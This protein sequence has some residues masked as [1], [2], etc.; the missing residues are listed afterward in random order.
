MGKVTIKYLLICFMLAM[1]RM[2]YA[3]D[4]LT[5][6]PARIYTVCDIYPNALAEKPPLYRVDGKIVIK[7]NW[8]R[9]M[10][11]FGAYLN[12]SHCK[13]G[14]IGVKFPT[15]DKWKVQ[16]KFTSLWFST[17][18]GSIK[19]EDFYCYCYGHMNYSLK[20]PFM[21]IEDAYVPVLDVHSLGGGH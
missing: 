13:D 8:G 5:S 3:D 21:E 12:D 1:P 4:V 11:G 2:T 9:S 19:S 20:E 18:T 17:F 16:Q 14:K 6:A 10:H 7:A 15:I